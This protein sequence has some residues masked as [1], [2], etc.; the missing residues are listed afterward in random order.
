MMPTCNYYTSDSLDEILIGGG[1]ITGD[2]GSY[3]IKLTLTMAGGFTVTPSQYPYNFRVNSNDSTSGISAI[4]ISHLSSTLM[5]VA[6]EDG[7]FFYSSDAGS[8]WNK[9]SGFPGVAG[10]WL[11]G[12]CVLPGATS[13]NTVY[14]AGSGYSNPPVYVSRNH[15]VSFTPMSTGLPPT[16][17]NNMAIVGN[18]SLIFA[19]TEAGPYVYVTS[20]NHWYSLA[21]GNIPTQ[22]WRSVEYIPAIN[23]VR[24]STYGRGIWDLKL[25]GPPITKVAPSP[26]TSSDVK[27]AP[28]P[29]KSGA[30]LTLFSADQQNIHLTI[31]TMEGRVV[32]DKQVATNIGIEMPGL[33]PGMYVYTCGTAAGKA[34][35]NGLLAV[36]L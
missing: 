22:N 11:Y 26:I 21:D 14:Y 20:H 15:G 5:Y 4:G 2:S 23:T 3:L 35:Q 6:A 19:A 27:I 31:Y 24:Y 13:I 1:N 17:V 25:N 8:T 34:T 9:T 18:D 7:T 10:N 30:P 16:L 28:N 12:A 29:V 33:V 36:G 32:L